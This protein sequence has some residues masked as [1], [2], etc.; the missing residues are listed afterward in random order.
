MS[1]AT[2]LSDVIV[3]VDH[4][5]TQR[6]FRYVHDIAATTGDGI[7]HFAEDAI[8]HDKSPV[9][10]SDCSQCVWYHVGQV[11]SNVPFP[12]V[13]WSGRLEKV[14]ILELALVLEV[15]AL[16]VADQPE[17]RHGTVFYK[18][19]TM[20]T[21]IIKRCFQRVLTLCMAICPHCFI[22]LAQ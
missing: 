17:T 4:V 19:I 20:N 9:T 7:T 6:T 16:D 13:N 3:S 15:N 22:A 18:T 12:V 10:T 2:S 14:S 1:T 11:Q 5:T 8:V 21:A